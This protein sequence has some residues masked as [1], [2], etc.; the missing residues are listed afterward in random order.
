MKKERDAQKQEEKQSGIQN[1]H[2]DTKSL[3]A[4]PNN[5]ST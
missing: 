1:H 2:A 3:K 4:C 5:E